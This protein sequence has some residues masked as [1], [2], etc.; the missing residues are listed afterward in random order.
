MKIGYLNC[1]IHTCLRHEILHK[2]FNLIKNVNDHCKV[3][4]DNFYVWNKTIYC[5]FKNKFKNKYQK[6]KLIK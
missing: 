3:N 1:L 2:F 6:I 5:K 4:T